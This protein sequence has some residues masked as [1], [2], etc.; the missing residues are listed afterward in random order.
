LRG[1]DH[2]QGHDSAG[3]AAAGAVLHMHYAVRSEWLLV[4]EIDYGVLFL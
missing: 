2:Q 3:E 4:E 1:A